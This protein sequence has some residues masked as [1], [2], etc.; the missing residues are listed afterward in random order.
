MKTKLDKVPFA[1]TYADMMALL[2]ASGV[3]YTREMSS[4][5]WEGEGFYIRS[6]AAS[7]AVFISKPVSDWYDQGDVFHNL[8]GPALMSRH[9][10]TKS[11]FINGENYSK[12]DW[13]KHPAVIEYQLVRCLNEVLDETE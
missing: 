4:S 11:Y 6:T 13:Q 7:V 2:M 9:G 12:E 1:E 8:A 5:R 3:P 10:D